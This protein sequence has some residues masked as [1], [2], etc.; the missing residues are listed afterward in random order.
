MS[1]S[2]SKNIPED[3]IDVEFFILRRK[4]NENAEFVPK[5]VQ[6]WEPANGVKKVKEAVEDIQNFVKNVFTTEGDYIDKQYPKN[7][8]N[9]RF[10]PYSDQPDLCDKK[11]I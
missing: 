7:V 10:C 8:S 6:Q 9:C 4:I 2:I 1:F 5:R 11:N 3:K